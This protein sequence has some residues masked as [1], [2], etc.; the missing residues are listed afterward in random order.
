MSGVGQ[1]EWI[2]T[3]LRIYDPCRLCTKSCH[4]NWILKWTYG[5]LISRFNICSWVKYYSNAESA[6]QS[7][8]FT[9]IF[10][11]TLSTII[12]QL[13]TVNVL[14][15]YFTSLLVWR[16]FKLL[17]NVY[18][19]NKICPFLNLNPHTTLIILILYDSAI[20]LIWSKGHYSGV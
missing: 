9:I 7:L 14:E 6:Q 3:L 4:I 10:R 1:L 12:T 17:I 19:L 2:W 13:N 5:W 8:C 11:L 16:F 18:L 15:V 20:T